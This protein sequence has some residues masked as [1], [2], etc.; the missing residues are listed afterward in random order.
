MK[1]CNKYKPSPV[2]LADHHR[3]PK[4]DCKDCVYFSKF[5]C[6]T[7]TQTAEQNTVFG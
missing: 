2:I 6:G 1:K 3:S 7:H 4:G 5:N